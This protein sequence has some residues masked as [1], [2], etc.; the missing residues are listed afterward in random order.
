M[1]NGATELQNILE[2]TF[3]IPFQVESGIDKGDPWYK[4]RPAEYSN[5]LFEVH[6]SFLNQ[7]RLNMELHPDTY[8]VPLLRDMANASPDKRATFLGYG[9]VF[10]ERR[11]KID[12]AINNIETSVVDSSDWPQ[13]WQNIRMKISKS[14]I[15]DDNEVFSPVK[16]V[17]DWGCLF[18]GMA[19]SLLEIVPIDNFSY[20]AETTEGDCYRAL[21]NRYERN[22]INR[23][24]CLAAKGYYCRVC[25]MDFESIYGELG[26]GF[27]HVHHNI[28][29]S[30]MGPKYVVNPL[31]ELEPVCPNCHVM[32]H[33]KDPPLG[34]EELKRIIAENKNTN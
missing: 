24:L 1:N 29:V 13:Q 11:A 4:I 19:L 14:P 25:G 16:I 2:N 10:A 6:I 5:E 3:D 26:T 31:N 33:R 8:A 28:P 21:T 12:F 15:V 17:S 30:K 18:I 23:K 20:A 27:I 34:I 7:L 32:L 9:K 22:P